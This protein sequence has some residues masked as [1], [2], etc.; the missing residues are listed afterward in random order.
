[1]TT[2]LSKA[3]DRQGDGRSPKIGSM[4]HHSDKPVLSLEECC[5]PYTCTFTQGNMGN[6]IVVGVNGHQHWYPIN[7]PVTIE[8]EAWETLRNIQKDRPLL[9]N[10]YTY[11]MFLDPIYDKN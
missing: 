7:E 2:Q 6:N 11:D 1:M 3:S 10:I 4:R 5:Q 9:P 8:R